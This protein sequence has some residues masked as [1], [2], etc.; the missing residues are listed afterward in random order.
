MADGPIT[1]QDL[2]LANQLKEV[3]TKIKKEFEA[4]GPAAAPVG[5]EAAKLNYTFTEIKK[6]LEGMGDASQALDEY[7]TN[8]WDKQAKFAT[9]AE[10]TLEVLKLTQKADIDRLRLLE[11]ALQRKKELEAR[12][13]IALELQKE[14]N[15]LEQESQSG[16]E[17]A[18]KAA[19]AAATAKKNLLKELEKEITLGKMSQKQNE[20]SLGLIDA[21]QESLGKTID[22]QKKR[23][24]NADK[25]VTAEGRKV[26]SGQDFEAT[27]ENQLKQM[28]GIQ[29]GAG[30]IGDHM[31]DVLASGKGFSGVMKIA[32]RTMKK[33]FTGANIL[34]TALGKTS[35]AVA[36]MKEQMKDAGSEWTALA[37]TDIRFVRNTGA[38][39]RYGQE[40]EDLKGKF[41]S[42]YMTFDE[43][44]KAYQGLFENSQAFTELNKEQ[45]EELALHAGILGRFNVDAGTLSKTIDHLNR[46]FGTSPKEI[47]S[48]T[49]N[50]TKF[51]RE[52]KVGPNK[53]LADL[54]ANMGTFMR[55]GKE[56]GVA[57]FKEL[58]VTAKKAGVEMSDL[59]NVAKQFD[60]FEGAAESAMKL[61][62]VLGGPLLNSVDLI[63]ANES[64]RIQL[65][66][67]AM[68]QSGK[69]FDQL[70]RYEKDLAAMAL[71]TADVAVA[72]K[73]FNDDNI[74]S[75]KEATAAIEENLDKQG[76]LAD[77]AK[78]LT[79]RKELDRIA[80]ERRAVVM[81]GLIDIAYNW[82]KLWD[83]IKIALAPI[84]A[85]FVGIAW[86]IGLVAKAF[87]FIMSLKTMW[88]ILKGIWWTIKAI[89]AGL[90]APVLG[91]IAAIA[92]LG[93]AMWIWWDDVKSI[94]NDVIGWFR[95]MVR[96]ISSF[97]FMRHSPS[98]MDLPG[99]FADAWKKAVKMVSSVF[100]TLATPFKWIG[101][102]I[103]G[104]VD[105]I[106][107]IPRKLAKAMKKVKSY[108]PTTKV[109]KDDWAITKAAKKGLAGAKSIASSALSLVGFE[110]G[111]DRTPAGAFIAGD[112]RDGQAKPELV[113]GRP[114]NAVINNENL[115][116]M[117]DVIKSIIAT[118]TTNVT[119]MAAAAA[120]PA[121]P[122]F[123]RAEE[124]VI[125]VTLRL[126]SD[127]LAKHSRRIA[128]EVMVTNLEFS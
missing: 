54:N 43:A 5:G 31:I 50:M 101:N 61:N 53:M 72:Q 19:K 102:K 11:E 15:N 30:S 92:A 41:N 32:N 126:D 39:Q 99:V 69:R 42:M 8:I 118:N 22:D 27:L 94:V 9:D 97:F 116:R 55:Y 111:T 74:S 60:T 34:K 86:A 18:K 52:L 35:E 125:N 67:D 127:V 88:L 124:Q 20:E 68:K 38:L 21:T 85:I 13:Q 4:L 45:R 24:K 51:A 120:A 28:T 25:L 89:F 91:V 66:K 16:D 128:N 106:M 6:H 37:E 107:A 112:S 46:G 90:S 113:V 123:D 47:K 2:E 105:M 109:E 122:G 57:M 84:A 10:K 1:P 36:K 29:T 83:E 7:F 79:T 75:I 14:I 3:I 96:K 103:K 100:K 76:D 56:K 82:F 71:G 58:A 40:L 62:Y 65:V 81:K 73:I 78:D 93:V 121:V 26:K 119:N 80:E 98:F 114:A 64:E 115:K 77:K 95:D 117:G 104:L 63:N 110:D 49:T 70:G 33:L 23:V 59:L 12:N 87:M 44:E 17:E 108:M 48:I